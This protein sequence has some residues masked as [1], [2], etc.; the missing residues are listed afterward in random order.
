ML[1]RRMS[2]PQGPTAAKRALGLAWAGEK[3]DS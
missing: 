3:L 2:Q 1:G